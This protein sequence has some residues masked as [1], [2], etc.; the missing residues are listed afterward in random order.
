MGVSSCFFA[1]IFPRSRLARGQRCQGVSTPLSRLVNRGP[2]ARAGRSG[3]SLSSS[4]LAASRSRK[5]V[6][7]TRGMGPS[8]IAGSTQRVFYTNHP[9]YSPAEMPRG[10]FR[11][12]DHLSRN[13]RGKKRGAPRN[14]WEGGPRPAPEARATEE[15]AR[16]VARAR[17]SR[18]VERRCRSWPRCRRRVRLRGRRRQ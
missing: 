7:G 14:L 18:V 5:K 12:L 4:S 15:R 3:L 2:N 8:G 16:S 11:F 9:L 6:R 17:V 10:R 13:V 1:A